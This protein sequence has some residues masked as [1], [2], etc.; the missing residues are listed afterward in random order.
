MPT[1]RTH[2]HSAYPQPV[3]I[4]TVR[5]HHCVSR[6]TRGRVRTH[7]SH[8]Q[9]IP[10]AHSHNPNPHR[11]PV[12][13]SL[14]RASSVGVDLM[15]TNLTHRSRTHSSYPHPIPTATA[16]P[17]LSAACLPSRCRNPS[18]PKLAPTPTTRTDIPATRTHTHS[19]H[20]PLGV[21]PHQLVWFSYSQPTPTPSSRVSSH[22]PAHTHSTYPQPVPTV[23]T[24]LSAACLP[25]R[26]RNPS[27]PDPVPTPTV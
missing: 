6:L 14:Q 8:T 11:Q 19:L 20:P 16:P 1:A 22:T 24:H 9:L 23:Y 18:Y 21:A 13:T 27:Y 2:T 3:L 4:S 5:T 15:G 26:C 12:P 25:S 7:S 17:H 10:T